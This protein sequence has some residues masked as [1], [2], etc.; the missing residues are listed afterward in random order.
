MGT[1]TWVLTSDTVITQWLLISE[2]DVHGL[3]RTYTLDALRALPPLL[4]PS[5]LPAALPARCFRFVAA[6]H[7]W[8]LLGTRRF[9]FASA[10]ASWT[11]SPLPVSDPEKAVRCSALVQGPLET[12]VWLAM[13]TGKIEIWETDPVG[14]SVKHVIETGREEGL[15]AMQQVSSFEVWGVTAAHSLVGWH[16]A[17]RQPKPEPLLRLDDARQLELSSLPIQDICATFFENH[18]PSSQPPIWLSTLNE[19]ILF[20]FQKNI[21]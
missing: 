20:T 12:E 1:H 19:V 2:A 3:R 10:R 9:S 21:N 16:I 11:P 13:E 6:D 5:P 7:L 17:S 14:G 4:P 18:L 15:V 8:A